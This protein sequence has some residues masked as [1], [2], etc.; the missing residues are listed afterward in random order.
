LIELLIQNGAKLDRIDIQGKTPL[1]YAA[2]LQSPSAI[3]TLLRHGA[4][5]NVKE[6]SG[7]TFCFYF[8]MFMMKT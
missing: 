5:V 7:F 3:V 4:T 2:S 8:Y 6:L 1:H